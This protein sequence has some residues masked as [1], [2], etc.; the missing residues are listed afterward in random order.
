MASCTRMANSS[1]CAVGL[2]TVLSALAV[3]QESTSGPAFE[4]ASI[5][6]VE[7]GGGMALASRMRSDGGRIRYENVSLASIIGAAYDLRAYQIQGPPWLA[8]QK[9]TVDATFPSGATKK[10]VPIMLVR[11]LAERF[12]L[13]AHREKKETPC[14]AL[15]ALSEGAKLGQ[16]I[17]EVNDPLA[18]SPSHGTVFAS[19]G[20]WEAKWMNMSD[21][22]A[23]LTNLVG[24]PVVDLTGIDGRFNFKTSFS[25]GNGS[26]A[27]PAPNGGQRGETGPSSEVSFFIDLKRLGLKLDSRKLPLEFLLIDHVE[28]APTPN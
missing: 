19:R 13:K 18:E 21:F 17:G 20:V 25:L 22:A 26:D 5:K 27:A 7:Q 24:R 11:L 2:M 4:V 8:S 6:M 16:P 12:M 15:L 14:F 9:Y 3:G 28:R 23:V 10:Q 1:I